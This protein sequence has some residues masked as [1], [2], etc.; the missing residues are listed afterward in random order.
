M[1]KAHP[2]AYF[3][4]EKASAST[5]Q[6]QRWTDVELHTMAQHELRLSGSVH[7]I[8]IELARLMTGR[9]ADAIKGKCKSPEYRALYE[10]LLA[11]QAPSPIP[12]PSASL[13]DDAP[14]PSMAV[15]DVSIRSSNSVADFDPEA[16]LIIGSVP[17]FL[18]ELNSDSTLRPLPMRMR[19][20][21]WTNLTFCWM[22]TL[23]LLFL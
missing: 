5:N 4:S 21:L 8:N 18:D 2:D 22:W 6:N 11:E 16:T 10:R 3:A 13:S 7:Y 1:R 20:R 9:T 15:P 17:Y 12:S 23:M 14:V 19:L